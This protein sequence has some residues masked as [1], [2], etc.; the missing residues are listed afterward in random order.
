MRIR[1]LSGLVLAAALIA[2]GC[3]QTTQTETPSTNE[4]AQAVI[5]IQLAIAELSVSIDDSESAELQ[6]AWADFRADMEAH[7]EAAQAE[8]SFDAAAVR[9]TID[10]FQQFLD[11][12]DE[13]VG[14]EVRASWQTVRE[15]IER[16]IEQFS[17]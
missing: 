13:E 9:S 16:L 11:T 6:A 1:R 17:A 14:D 2:P 4:I 7:F 8:G 15:T 5:E 10:D 3:T 12:T